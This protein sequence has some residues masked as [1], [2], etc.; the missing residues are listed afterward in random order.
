MS[1]AENVLLILK[2]HIKCKLLLQRFLDSFWT[3]PFW[4]M[5]I[6]SLC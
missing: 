6:A 1:P 4:T 2:K 5:Y 3:I